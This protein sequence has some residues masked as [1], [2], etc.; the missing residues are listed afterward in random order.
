VNN[1]EVA[2]GS[3]FNAQDYQRGAKVVILGP[4]VKESLFGNASPLGQKIRMGSIIV[5]VIGVL[6]S[7]GGIGVMNIMLVSVLERTREI[8]IRKALGRR[9]AGYMVAGPH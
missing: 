1:L 5:T 9:R 4:N 2:I 8:G 6:E 3:F 7:K